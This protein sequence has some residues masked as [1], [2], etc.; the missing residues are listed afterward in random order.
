MESFIASFKWYFD[1]AMKPEKRNLDKQAS[2]DLKFLVFL[3]QK[4]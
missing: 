1:G 4:N 3:K 2:Q